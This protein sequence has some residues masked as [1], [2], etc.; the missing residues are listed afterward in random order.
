MVGECKGGGT[1][2]YKRGRQEIKTR[3][4]IEGLGESGGDVESHRKLFKGG[5]R[6]YESWDGKVRKCENPALGS[7]VVILCL[8]SVAD[9]KLGR[10]MI[11]CLILF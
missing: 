9:F 8:G 7:S 1:R 11:V 10:D 6:K 4:S 2:R 5:T 3:N